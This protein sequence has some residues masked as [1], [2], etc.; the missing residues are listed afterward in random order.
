MKGPRGKIYISD[1]CQKD[2]VEVEWAIVDLKM[3][4]P[5]NSGS[6]FRDLFI[7]LHNERGEEAH[8]N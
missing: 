6:A 2:L 8:E 5:Q 1:F 3:L 4:C 7:I